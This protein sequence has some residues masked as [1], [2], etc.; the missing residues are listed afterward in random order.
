MIHADIQKKRRI[1]ISIWSALRSFNKDFIQESICQTSTHATDMISKINNSETHPDV[2]CQKISS[3][4]K[5]RLPKYHWF[6]KP[7]TKEVMLGLY[8]LSGLLS[9]YLAHPSAP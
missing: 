2:K 8:L 7:A 4:G 9:V 5:T 6:L 1:D 3:L